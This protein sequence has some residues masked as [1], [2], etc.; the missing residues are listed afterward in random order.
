MSPVQ[1]ALTGAELKIDY[2][3][4]EQDQKLAANYNL[5]LHQNN[6][7]GKVYLAGDK[8][9]LTKDIVA[10]MKVL[11][12]SLQEDEGVNLPPY[13][14]LEDKEFLEAWDATL[15][16]QEQTVPPEF[17]EL[18]IFIV[19]AIPDQYFSISLANQNIKFSINQDGLADVIFS[20]TQK[21]A[22]EK[23]RFADI[24]AGLA[25]AA[26]PEET[27]ESL[28]S[29]ILDSLTETVEYPASPQELREQ[30]TEFINLD[31]LTYEASLL[32]QG[33]SKF[34]IAMDL[35]D[36]GKTLGNM[37]GGVDWNTADG[38]VTTGKYNFAFAIQNDESP[39]FKTEGDISGE[40]SQDPEKAL[41]SYQMNIDLKGPDDTIDALHVGL[42]VDSQILAGL[43]NPIQVPLLT[44][45]NSMDLEILMEQPEPGEIK[46]FIDGIPVRFDVAPQI[47]NGRIMV[48]LRNIAEALNCRG[49]WV[50]L[51]Q[52]K[53]SREEIVI[54]MYANDPRYIVNGAEKQL[55]APPFIQDGRMLLPLRFIAEELGCKVHYDESI[56]TVFIQSK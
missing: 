36:E 1:N 13:L 49:D 18:L 34:S 15:K 25:L 8:I 28:R 21:V 11:D 22:G 53:I 9:I 7:Q 29:D 23:E 20:V 41:S 33:S 52:I 51:N 24:I 43:Q 2:Q 48:P 3:L 30:L 19:E 27:R 38:D 26:S 17:K 35:L 47:Q 4:D 39:G 16:P 37:K 10:L 5:N 46:V 14:Y 50:D 54:T 44:K 45:A 31:E 40:F 42:Q 56:R 32:P 6:V 12:P 55:D